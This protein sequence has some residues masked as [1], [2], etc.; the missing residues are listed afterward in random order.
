M[1]ITY[2]P[3]HR[4]MDFR[5]DKEIEYLCHF[6]LFQA[7]QAEMLG[8][9]LREVINEHYGYPTYQFKGGELL[10]NGIYKYPEDPDLYP[11][12]RVETDAETIFMY[13]YE[14]VAIRNKTTDEYY[15]TRVD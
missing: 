5:S 11:L 15:V 2:D 6:I 3:L 9:G 13:D 12:C 8:M 7:T 1:I 4:H 14:M 10:D